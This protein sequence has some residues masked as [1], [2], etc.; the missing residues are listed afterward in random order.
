MGFD[1]PVTGSELTTYEG[2]LGDRLGYIG[3]ERYYLVSQG[4]R[5][6]LVQVCSVSSEDLDRVLKPGRFEARIDG[7]LAILGSEVSADLGPQ[8]SAISGSGSYYSW[9]V[10]L[11]LD[12]DGGQ[13]F[14]EIGG[15]KKGRPIDMFLDR[16]E[17]TILVVDKV[18]Y[19]ILGELTEDKDDP[20]YDSYVQI[21][22][23]R[24]LI[25]L[26]VIENNTFD[27]E[28][29]SA[30]KDYKKAILAG[31]EEHI[32]EAVREKLEGHGFTTVRKPRE[33]KDYEEWVLD[34][35]GLRSSPRL[36]CDPCTQCKYAAQIAGSA[37]TLEGAKQ[38][39][40]EIMSLLG[41]GMLPAN[42]GI[43]SKTTIPAC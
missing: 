3:F 34:L 7:E 36:R 20:S 23:N 18:T 24:S 22:E 16:P 21:V 4:N 9:Y 10:S 8:G 6:I 13:R 17:N 31:D 15:D 33:G 11:R 40:D 1:E 19:T 41:F 2:I 5:S 27:L 14:C 37:F 32:P 38:D 42:L 12:Y 30:L 43:E 25:P 29:L 26:L 35:V 28:R 39:R